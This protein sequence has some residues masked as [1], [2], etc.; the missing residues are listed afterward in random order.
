MG[1]IKRYEIICLHQIYKTLIKMIH[2]VLGGQS[3]QPCLKLPGSESTRGYS[4]RIIDQCARAGVGGVE[5][6]VPSSVHLGICGSTSL[7]QSTNTFKYTKWIAT[8]S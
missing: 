1:I 2:N 7:I 6:V 5:G 4:L 8:R 3:A